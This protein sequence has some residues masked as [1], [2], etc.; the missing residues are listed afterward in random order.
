[1]ERRPRVSRDRPLVLHRDAV[2]WLEPLKRHVPFG[3]DNKI[4]KHSLQWGNGVDSV[5]EDACVARRNDEFGD[6]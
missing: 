2:R 6:V 3:S 5:R 1:M 4:H